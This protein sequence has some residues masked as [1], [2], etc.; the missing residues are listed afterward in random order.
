MLAAGYRWALMWSAN[1]PF[2]VF[3]HSWD[4]DLAETIRQQFNPV[5]ARFERN[6]GRLD[7]IRRP[8]LPNLHDCSRVGDPEFCAFNSV[9][10]A[11]SIQQVLHLIIEREDACTAA[12]DHV[13]LSR[14]DLVFTTR[15][16][17]T[18]SLAP[19]ERVALQ[20]QGIT[21][22]ALRK[23][24]PWLLLKA[25][26]IFVLSTPSHLR[27]MALLFE[28]IPNGTSHLK[29]GWYTHFIRQ[30]VTNGSY[31]VETVMGVSVARR[32]CLDPFGLGAARLDNGS[33]WAR[34]REWGWSCEYLHKLP[35]PTNPSLHSRSLC[36]QVCPGDTRCTSVQV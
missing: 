16:E 18:P 1:A 34:M 17:L 8:L 25:D 11:F 19:R 23:A 13:V 22:P 33:N 10:A 36:C 29:W 24:P 15:V 26:G 27:R 9:S 7:V 4:M 14:L 12:Y 21:E 31:P 35:R 30:Q 3:V 20:F 2:D 6:S 28:S 5:A 32:I